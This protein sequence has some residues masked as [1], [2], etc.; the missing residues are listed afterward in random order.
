M[1]NSSDA[2]ISYKHLEWTTATFLDDKDG[3]DKNLDSEKGIK[4]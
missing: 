2:A 4:V 3:S 1:A